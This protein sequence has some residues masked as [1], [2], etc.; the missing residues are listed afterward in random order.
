VKMRWKI[1]LT[2]IAVLLL[3]LASTA[4]LVIWALRT[5]EG[6]RVLLKVFS[7]VSPWKIEAREISGRLGDELRLEGVEVHWSHG[8]GGA[9]SLYLNW[10]PSE[11]LQRKLAVKELSLADVRIR[12]NRPEAKEA[13]LTFN[14]W[15][16]IPFWFFK[17]Q[18]RLES[19]R[20]SSLVYHRLREELFGLDQLT[21]ELR[22]DGGA[23]SVSDFALKSPSVK[24]TGDMKLAFLHPAMSLHLQASVPRG[25]AGLNSLSLKLLLEPSANPEKATGKVLALARADGVDRLRLESDL[26]LTR[27]VLAFRKL[28][29]SRQGRGEKGVLRAEGKVDFGGK[30]SLVM[31]AELA[32]LNLAPE[33][34]RV[35]DFSG[36]I[37][38]KGSPDDFRGDLSLLNKVKGWQGSGLSAVLRGNR[39]SLEITSLSASWLDGSVK[40]RGKITWAKGVV[41]QGTLQGRKLNPAG[42]NPDLK[43]AANINLEGWFAWRKNTPPEVNLKAELLES[44][45]KGRTIS[46]NLAAHLKKNLLQIARLNLQGSGVILQAHGILEEKVDLEVKIP[47]LSRL[48]PGGKGNFSARGWARFRDNRIT[49][50][51]DG[52]GHDLDLEKIHARVLDASLHLRESSLQSGP[53]LS[54]EA[55]AQGLKAGPLPAES[56]VLKAE[57]TPS[58]HR[59][60]L[61]LLPKEG[62]IQ[63]ELAGGYENGSWKGEVEELM[64]RDSKGVWNLE[65]PAKFLVS[66]DQFLLHSLVVKQ[67]RGERIQ[68][69][70]DLFFHPLSGLIRAGWGN[71]DLARANPWLP[72]GNLAGQTSGTFAA[73]WRDSG[74]EIS[75]RLNLKGTLAYDLLKVE[76]S[77]AQAGVDWNGKGLRASAG[78]RLNHGGIFDAEASSPEPFKTSLPREGKMDARW[79]SV[80]LT[81]LPFLPEGLDMKG[82]SS[83]RIAGKWF[84]GLR[85]D[86]TG[87]TEI[88]E[89][90]VAWKRGP[91]PVSLALSKARLDFGWREETLRGNVSLG[92]AEHGRLRGNFQLPLAARFP[93]SFLPQGP[94]QVAVQAQLE[95]NGLLPALYPRAIRKSRGTVDLRLQAEGTRDKPRFKGNIQVSGAAFQFI[96]RP[97]QKASADEEG[98]WDL[99]A[100]SASAALDWEQRGFT[101]TLALKIKEQGSLEGRLSSPDPAGFDL[102]KEGSADMALKDLDLAILRPWLPEA[103]ALEGAISGRL[104][105]KWLADGSLDAEGGVKVSHGKISWQGKSGLV[106]AALNQADLDFF[107]RGESLRGGLSI[108]LADYGSLKGNFHLPLPA[109]L[110]PRF[111]P[112]GPVLLTLKGQFQEKGLMAAVFPGI[113][114]ETRGSIDL[115]LRAEGKWES[116]GLTGAVELGK[117][118]ALFP[119]LGIRVEDVSA[120]VKLQNDQI[121]VETFRARSGPGHLEGMATLWLKGWEIDRFKG[122]LR[123]EKFQAL[124]LPDLRIQGGPTL[125]FQGTPKSI[126]VR[127]EVNLPEVSLFGKPEKEMVRPSPDA[128]ILNRPPS[129]KREIGLDIQ[130][131]V[132]L[133]K[134]VLVK[135]GGIDA[136]V[137]GSSNLKILGFSPEEISAQGE[138]RVAEGYYS[139]YGL[140]L[141]ISRGLVLF[142]GPVDNPTL[143]IQ[144]MRK[145]NEVEAG[146]TVSGSLKNPVVKL[147]SN[148][149]MGDTDILSYIVLGRPLNRGTGDVNLLMTAAGALLSQGESVYV[150]DKIKRELG[151]DTID[152]QAGSGDVTRSMITVGKYLS[153]ELY[154]S[155][156]QT[157]FTNT[158]T[159]TARYNITKHWEVETSR[160]TETGIDLFYKIEFY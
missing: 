76:I 80:D 50:M 72:R 53:F 30:L 46:G 25:Y 5:T 27:T 101:G 18:G 125:S 96:S 99:E 107:W 8:V 123:G 4:A 90:R 19:F 104:G 112:A 15:P 158:Q 92:S 146:V 105:G 77:S 122:E 65:T 113:I 130:V 147:Y 135:T 98:G 114:Q 31:N 87:E 63:V 132:V 14:R 109:R 136:R 69:T 153:P 1:A 148:P 52:Q 108:S 73:R 40:G 155:L 12:D 144:A 2:V 36:K 124:Y 93:P 54:L 75:G 26:D 115:D 154:V 88:L 43:G 81:L 127:G 119:T 151:L 156:G 22:W 3:I 83:G 133:G 95:D 33:L 152:I 110:P 82:R 78:V 84:N 38:L 128:V 142:S 71:I 47:D 68:A 140:H 121:R 67:D 143:D 24:A 145:V 13:P 157:I 28:I 35:T 116:P 91:K 100:L 89:G 129:P 42:F 94:F 11:L 74:A 61:A 29:F 17:L 137:E 60:N 56:A 9:A 48:I 97:A 131:R 49:G 32:D 39:E 70:A 126:S 120:R 23:L 103:L 106:S 59:A 66:S 79:Q 111:L 139:G 41:V 57:G 141:K 159:L 10:Q 21:A 16:T 37:A 117:G 20:V 62:E 45:F 51:L 149:A 58:R 7:L 85:F 134:R 44:R 55:R 6:S 86:A 34:G 150:Q 64:A 138:V 102:P 118:G 160:G